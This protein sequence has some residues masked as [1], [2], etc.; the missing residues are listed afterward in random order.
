MCVVEAIS[1]WNEVNNKKQE[2]ERLKKE[3]VIPVETKTTTGREDFLRRGMKAVETE[4]VP[5]K[6]VSKQSRTRETS[7]FSAC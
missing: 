4:I 7:R 6:F 2:G 3:E 1:K 5:K